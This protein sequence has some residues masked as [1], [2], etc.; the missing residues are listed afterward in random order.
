MTT[1]DDKIIE[2]LSPNEILGLTIVGEARGEA[3]EGQV[4]VGCVIR[5]RISRHPEKYKSYTD[6]CFESKQF[7]CW[8][9][10]N[11]NRKFLLELADKLVNEGLVTD[12]GIKQCMFVAKGIS[13]WM[14]MDNTKGALHYM[15]TKLYYGN[16]PD[17]AINAY[18]TTI[19]NHQIFFN[20]NE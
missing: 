7:S 12:I 15:T 5:N 19:F 11:P 20:I 18:N 1:I 13:E 4:A 6:V 17:W 14:I 9:E 10:N 16:K 8:N 2:A 3:I